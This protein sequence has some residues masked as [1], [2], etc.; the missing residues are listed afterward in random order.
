MTKHSFV[1]PRLAPW[2]FDPRHLHSRAR[3]AAQLTIAEYTNKQD[4]LHHLYDEITG[5]KETFETLRKKDPDKWNR[6]MGNE[7]GRLAQGVGKRMTSGNNNIYY[8][9]KSKIP[10]GKK[11]TYGTIV[12]DYRPLKDDPYRV[13]LTVGGDKLPYFADAGSP[14]ASLLEAKLLFNSIVSTPGAKFFSADIK[15]YFLCSPMD[16]YEYM[17]LPL[18][19]IPEEIRVQYNLYNLVESDGYVY[20]EIRKGMYGLKQAARL[21]FDNLVKLLAPHGYH[22]IRH[23]PGIWRHVSRPTIFTLC[24]DDFGVK[25]MNDDDAHHLINAIKQNFKCS[26]DWEGKHYLGLDLNWDYT[27]RHV[28]ISMNGYIKATLKKFLHPTP[29][30]PQHSPHEWQLPAYGQKIQ[31]SKTPDTTPKLNATDTKR[32]QAISGTLLYYSRAV[33]PILLPALNEI[34]MQQSAPTQ[35]TMNKCNQLLDYVATYPNATIRYKASKMILQVDTDAAYLV[36]P[37]ARSRCAG[38]YYLTND[39]LDNPPPNGPIYT[40]CKTIRNVVSSSAEAETHGAF[41]NAQEIIPIKRMLE[42]MG[43]KQP[44]NGTP[45]KTD[46]KT[47]HDITTNLI[48]PRKSKTWDMRYHWLEDQINLKQIFLHWKPGSKNWA[49]YFTKHW[50][51]AYHKLMRYKY[52]HKLYY[53][54]HLLPK[55]IQNSL[56]SSN[57]EGVL[58]CKPTY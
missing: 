33:D 25:Y 51:P 2:K 10:K 52:L 7:L 39:S 18:H 13:R 19:I 56:T 40:L 28:D 21:A 15:D 9:P 14:A 29:S 31:Y 30:K 4:Y 57:C 48:K 12:C 6:A 3:A 42:A 44:P 45:L 20:I 46:N 49:D 22:P 11:I 43:H 47:S 54:T 16:N 8:I 1:K 53:I 34:A 35:N 24:V 26:I 41:T 5:K 23:M 37:K 58:Q 27:N 38:H 36:L 17:K 32:V 50:A 55:V